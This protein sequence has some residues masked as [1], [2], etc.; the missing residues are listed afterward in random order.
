MTVPDPSTGATAAGIYLH[1]PF[2]RSKCH[3]CGFNSHPAKGHDLDAYLNALRR[4]LQKMAA[5]A[6]S[7]SHT[8]DTIFIGGG[9]PTIYA[10]AQIAALLQECLA[11]FPIEKAAE[12][13][14]EANPNTITLEKLKVLKECGINRLSIGVQSFADSRLKAIG[15]T[16]N[17]A[18]AL[19]SLKLAREAGFTNLNLDLIYG[20]P[21]QSIAE[22]RQTLEIAVALNPEHLALYELT[23]DDNTRFAE[24]ARQGRLHLPDDDAL[25]AMEDLAY[26]ILAE[27][28][29]ERYEISNFCRPGY[30]CRHNLNYWHNG[31]YLGLGAGA[32]SCLDGLRLTNVA[33]PDL[34]TC[35]A[36]TDAPVFQEAEA[37]NLE[38]R[39]RETVIMGLR[40]IAGISLTELQQRFGLTPQDYYGSR[41]SRLADLELIEIRDN[42][43][44]LTAKGLP[45]ANQILAELV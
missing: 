39:F 10:P 8:F 23:V 38:A 30:A 42:T 2:C 3:Y 28:G 43:L 25:A 1:L 4:T 16:H 33:D 44:R 7:A 17:G 5:H 6:W 11:L 41:L 45:I 32:V 14:M 9:T 12:I 26:G 22:F 27:A 15:R 34:F 13:S 24:L 21:G 37:L 36:A 40:L 35:L 20:L 19:T 31:S 18:E 29:Y